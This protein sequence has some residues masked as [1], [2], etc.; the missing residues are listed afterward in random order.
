MGGGAADGDQP[1]LAGGCGTRVGVFW[2][3]GLALKGLHCVRVRRYACECPSC[4]G[5]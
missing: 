4:M 1:A 3:L 5:G 2:A